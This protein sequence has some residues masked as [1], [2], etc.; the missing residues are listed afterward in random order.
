L[1][2]DCADKMNFFIDQMLIIR[3]SPVK[4]G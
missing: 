1:P 4:K 2:K 3:K